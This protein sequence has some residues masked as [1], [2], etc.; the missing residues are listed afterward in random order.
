VAIPVS[1]NESKA[2]RAAAEMEPKDAG[3]VI[4][5]RIKAYSPNTP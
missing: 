1:R 3:P 4:I 5:T 2:A